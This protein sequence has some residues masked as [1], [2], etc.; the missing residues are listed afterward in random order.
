MKRVTAATAPYAT[1]G[2][3]SAR[4]SCAPSRRAQGSQM[5]LAVRFLGIHCFTKYVKVAFFRGTSLR[6]VPGCECT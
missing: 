5:E 6:P 4:S 2:A 3:A 1:S